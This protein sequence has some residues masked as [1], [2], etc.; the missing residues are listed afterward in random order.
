MLSTVHCSIGS[1]DSLLFPFLFFWS[2]SWCSFS[3]SFLFLAWTYS[4]WVSSSQKVYFNKTIGWWKHGIRWRKKKPSFRLSEIACTE[5]CFLKREV[6]N[7]NY[8]SLA[9]CRASHCASCGIIC[10]L[11]R[12]TKSCSNVMENDSFSSFERC[13]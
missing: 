4:S 6:F 9:D 12:R 11:K 13:W 10:F 3:E 8:F 5:L 2:F 1:N 7:N